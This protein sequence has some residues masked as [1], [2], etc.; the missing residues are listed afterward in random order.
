MQRHLPAD[1]LKMDTQKK[2]CLK[3]LLRELDEETYMK[4]LHRYIVQL[5]PDVKTAQQVYE[6]GWNY[7]RRA[8][9][10]KPVPVWHAAVMWSC[11]LR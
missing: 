7:V 1:F 11:G 6:N 9:I 4:Q 5:D 2:P 10:W 8:T 3:C